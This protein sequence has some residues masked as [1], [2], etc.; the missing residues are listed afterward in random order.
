MKINELCSA[1]SGYT[2]L[3]SALR[4]ELLHVSIT[5]VTSESR[6]DTE[7]KVLTP[8]TG[9]RAETVSDPAFYL[10]HH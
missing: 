8:K 9:L 1:V 2:R 10:C 7:T 3:R 5:V 6:R 4:D